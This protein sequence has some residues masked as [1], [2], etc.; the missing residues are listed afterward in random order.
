M[1]LY[2]IIPTHST[3]V[4]SGNKSTASPYRVPC[5]TV[6]VYASKT[7][8]M[9]LHAKRINDSLNEFT[10]R[11]YRNGLNGTVLYCTVQHY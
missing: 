5:G 7:G 1:V 6:Q 11:R 4:A 9:S 10:H 8:M 3:G 2:C